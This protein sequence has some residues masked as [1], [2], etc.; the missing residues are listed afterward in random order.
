MAVVVLLNWVTQ[1]L[2]SLFTKYFL[3]IKFNSIYGAPAKKISTEVQQEEPSNCP[4][5]LPKKDDKNTAVAIFLR[6]GKPSPPPELKKEESKKEEAIKEQSKFG[7]F[8]GEPK[9][10]L[11]RSEN[12][13]SSIFGNLSSGNGLF[14]SYSKPVFAGGNANPFGSSQ[15]F[16]LNSHPLY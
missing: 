13:S 11:E 3:S 1:I 6:R 2:I 5:D 12:T 10:G 8:G 4:I 15:P 7:A 9:Y 14:G 16:Q